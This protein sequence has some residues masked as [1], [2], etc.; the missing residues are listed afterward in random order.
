MQFNEYLCDPAH[1]AMLTDL[2]LNT[3]NFVINMYSWIIH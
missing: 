2:F 1:L 3:S